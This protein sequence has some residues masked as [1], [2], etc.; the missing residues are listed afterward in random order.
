MVLFVRPYHDQMRKFFTMNGTAIKTH[1]FIF[2]L[3]KYIMFCLIRFVLYKLA[4]VPS[5]KIKVLHEKLNA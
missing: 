5:S 2:N 3:K 1:F 4:H